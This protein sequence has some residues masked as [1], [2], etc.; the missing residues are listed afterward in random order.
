MVSNA[1]AKI[2]DVS[3]KKRVQGDRVPLASPQKSAIEKI[4]HNNHLNAVKQH[5]GSSI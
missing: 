2:T 4:A 1:S 3:Q 5:E